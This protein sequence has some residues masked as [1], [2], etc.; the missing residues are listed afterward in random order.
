MALGVR[1]FSN[2]RES[3][4]EYVC[5]NCGSQL[6]RSTSLTPVITE[7]CHVLDRY[8]GYCPVCGGQLYRPMFI[9]TAFER[10]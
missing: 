8:G 1:L 3:G 2:S 4:A 9:Q 10:K 6:F 5:T 7:A